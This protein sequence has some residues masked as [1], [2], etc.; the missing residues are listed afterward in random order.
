MALAALLPQSASDDERIDVA[1]LPPLA[2]P[3]CGVNLVVVGGAKRHGEFITDFESQTF[4][5]CIANV[6]GVG[7]IRPQITQGWLATKRRC[8]FERIRFGSA[9]VSTLL[10]TFWRVSVR[11]SEDRSD[12][13]PPCLANAIARPFICATRF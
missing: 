11:S 8:S 10:S 7:G 3:A 6:M 9:M 2:L 1:L 4:W 13:S 5:L 12:A